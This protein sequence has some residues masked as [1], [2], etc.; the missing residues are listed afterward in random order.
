MLVAAAVAAGVLA[1]GLQVAH[2]DSSGRLKIANDT[3][4]LQLEVGC[5]NIE[6]LDMTFASDH[7]RDFLVSFE[8]MLDKYAELLAKG[9][10][11]F[12]HGRSDRAVPLGHHH[13]RGIVLPM[14]VSVD[15]G[16]KEISIRKAAGCTSLNTLD[17]SVA[18]AKGGSTWCIP[19]LE[20]R[21]VATLSTRELDALLPEHIPIRLLKLDAQGSDLR[22]LRSMPQHFLRRIWKVR[23]ESR[24]AQCS[25]LY[26]SPDENCSVAHDFMVDQGFD[27]KRCADTPKRFHI[28]RCTLNLEYTRSPS[29][30]INAQPRM[31]EPGRGGT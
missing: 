21:V 31:Q 19:V 2:T 30:E 11:R 9:N 16:P 6:T 28:D 17:T 27:G 5:S 3:D 25:W 7:P 22:L 20:R 12:N 4:H 18:G 29:A 24:H 8:P 26:G 13:R 23:L 10:G 15:G 1:P 14:A